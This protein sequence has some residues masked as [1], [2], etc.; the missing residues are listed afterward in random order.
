MKHMVT[1]LLCLT[2]FLGLGCQT[3][4]VKRMPMPAVPPSNGDQA[5][6]ESVPGLPF[7]VKKAACL[8]TVVWLEPV[9][10]L[11]LELVTTPTSGT[12]KPTTVSLG[13]AILSLTQLKAAQNL[14]HSLNSDS[15]TIQD[16]MK[17]WIP[18]A[19]QDG[20]PYTPTEFP[21][22]ANRI[23]ISNTSEPQMYVDYSQTYYIN[24]KRPL[25]GSV[26]LDNK[27]A[28]DG[29][30]TEV[31]AEMEDKTIQAI[32]TGIKD[33]A[34]AVGTA[35]KSEVVPSTVQHVKLSV[36]S[37]GFKHTISKF[38][39]LK[40]LP[41]DAGGSD[42]TA[43]YRYSRSEV[44]AASDTKKPDTKGSKITVSGEIV[45]PEPKPSMDDSGKPTPAPASAETKKPPK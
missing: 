43:P 11:T 5:K 16:V 24:A 14:F 33:I 19:K 25:A 40:G 22:S 4:Q 28:S 32:A 18:V 42:L 10:T 15:P 2:L 27:L 45:L 44:T 20:T 21:A 37:A 36:A 31:S 26:K 9:Y 39:P 38:E 41:C 34:S 35:A 12:A 7:Y 3:L 17:A 29:T 13:S 8:H 30:L 23:L 1:V 6:V